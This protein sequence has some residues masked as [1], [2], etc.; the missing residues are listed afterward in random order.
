MTMQH[1]PTTPTS[2][3]PPVSRGN[4]LKAPKRPTCAREDE[5]GAVEAAMGAGVSWGRD[6]NN[7]RYAGDALRH[8]LE[9][10]PDLKAYIAH[11]DQQISTT[12]ADRPLVRK[13]LGRVPDR[14]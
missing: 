8:V 14:A 13:T 2:L 1:D 3:A 7:R 4:H 11:L 9:Q 5:T 12:K 10:C 6:Q